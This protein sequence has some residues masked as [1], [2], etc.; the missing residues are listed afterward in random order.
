[1]PRERGY[2]D[3]HFESLV[4]SICE[5]KKPYL[6]TDEA[7]EFIDFLLSNERKSEALIVSDYVMSLHPNDSVLLIQRATFLVELRRLEEARNIL[8]Q[9]SP[10]EDGNP[11]LYLAWGDLHVQDGDIE[12]ALASYDRAVECENVGSDNYYETLLMIACRLNRDDQY[13]HCFKYV[14]LFLKNRPHDPDILFELA[15]ALDKVGKEQESIE[16]YLEVLH[17]SPMSDISWYNYALL[18]TRTGQLEEANVAFD[19]A[20]ALNPEFP[21]AYVNYGN[22]LATSEKYL[23][24]IAQYATYISMVQDSETFDP[25]VYILVAD[26][27]F[28]WAYL[29]REKLIQEDTS[30]NN[31]WY[32]IPVPEPQRTMYE[33]ALEIYKISYSYSC[34]PIRSLLQGADISSLLGDNTTAIKL[35][36]QAIKEEPSYQGSY[37]MLSCMYERNNDAEGTM[38]AFI[39]GM[40]INPKDVRTWIEFARLCLKYTESIKYTKKAVDLYREIAYKNGYIPETRFG[41]VFLMYLSGQPSKTIL[42]ILAELKDFYPEIFCDACYDSSFREMMRKH[43]YID[44][45][46][47]N[48]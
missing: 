31:S 1:M 46:N 41:D 24:A 19:R 30:D 40:S 28:N 9:I 10:F 29:E 17:Y 8:K 11:D 22:L 6:D 27:C 34:E 44:L 3:Q 18:C 4:K 16:T 39:K 26:C 13:A 25:S 15:Y 32:Q 45:L 21:D 12:T 20:I 5:G 7:E 14:D 43:P 2:N 33:I 23:E 42:E 48:E 38:N 47:D 35:V 36:E 37:F